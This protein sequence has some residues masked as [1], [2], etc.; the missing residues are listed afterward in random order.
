MNLNLVNSLS[1]TTKSPPPKNTPDPNPGIE[2]DATTARRKPQVPDCKRENNTTHT[3]ISNLR[4]WIGENNARTRQQQ[5]RKIGWCFQFLRT[6]TRC[7]MRRTGF[8]RNEGRDPMCVVCHQVELDKS[9]ALSFD[10][11]PGMNLEQQE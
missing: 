7:A 11:T 8:P 10:S 1:R 5:H 2:S 3:K 4:F 9:G 6:G